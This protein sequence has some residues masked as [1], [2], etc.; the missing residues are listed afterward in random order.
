MNPPLG[1][2]PMK[3]DPR[4]LFRVVA[5]A[6]SVSWI[7]LLVGMYFKRIAETTEL[8]VVI[9]APIHG[10]IVLA[11]L[12]AVYYGRRSF[13]WTG[14]TALLAAFAAVPPSGTVVFEVW[15]DRRNLLRTAAATSEE[16]TPVAS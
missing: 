8:G 1:W 12:V 16:K 4:N 13:G 7:G 9:F 2:I 11:Y 15:A 14:R 3:L 10:V 5:F 6:E